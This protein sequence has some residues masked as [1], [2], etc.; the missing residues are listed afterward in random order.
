MPAYSL[1]NI[2]LDNSMTFW[3]GGG[4][5]GR[6]HSPA[7]YYNYMQGKFENGIPLT[8][9]GYGLSGTIPTNYILVHLK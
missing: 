5:G 2:S 3:P 9:G 8:Y 1:G 7:E 6:P 4:S